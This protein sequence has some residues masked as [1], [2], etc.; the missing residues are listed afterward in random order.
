MQMTAK[1]LSHQPLGPLLILLEPSLASGDYYLKLRELLMNFNILSDL[2]KIVTIFCILCV[3][4]IR[5]E[6]NREPQ[7]ARHV[8]DENRYVREKRGLICPYRC[9]NP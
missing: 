8:M 5:G 9:M 2:L 4:R 7:L 6:R 3:H 1:R